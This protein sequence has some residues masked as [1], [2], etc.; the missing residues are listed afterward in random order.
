MGRGGLGRSQRK[1]SII[2]ESKGLQI[3]MQRTYSA[4]Q[5]EQVLQALRQSHLVLGPRL[6]RGQGEF[7]SKDYVGY[8]EIAAAADLVTDRRS[9]FSPKE[10][11][12]PA[13]ETLLRF[14]GERG[15]EPALDPRPVLL[16]LRACDI[17][18][19]Q[20]LDDIFLRHGAVEDFYYARRRRRCLVLL[21]ECTHSFDTCFCVSMGTNTATEFAAAFRFEPGRVTVQVRD[22]SL[23]AACGGSGEPCEYTPSFVTRNV[24]EVSVPP[25]ASVLPSHFEH[26]LWNEYTRRCIACG[27]CNLCCVTCSCFTMQDTVD[28]EPP[29]G[30][31]RRRRWAG[32]HVQGFTD[33]AGGHRFRTRNGERMRFKTMHKIND[34]HKRFGSHMCVGCG[35]CDEVCP[36]HISFARCINLLSAAVR[37]G[38]PA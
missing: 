18:G 13:R 36:E 25:V 21:L 29:H 12:F 32:C 17:N 4:E 19:F 34:F 6:C 7:Y 14:A 35:R 1:Y 22:G 5:F 38:G 2:L 16:F 23:L 20:R 24:V 27:R 9:W 26:P 8:G 28:A 11:V 10:A 30:A 15:I 33:M 31:L 37:Q 3:L